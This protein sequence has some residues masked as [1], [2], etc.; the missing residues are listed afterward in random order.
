M[1][2][3]TKFYGFVLALLGVV[4]LT[5]CDNDDD[6]LRLSEVPSVVLAALDAKYPDVKHAEW[7]VKQG[8]YVAD[9]WQ[10]GMETHVWINKNA[11]WKMTELDLGKNLSLL[12]QAVQDA[13]QSGQYASWRVDDIDKYERPDRTFYVIEVE[14]NGQ[15]DHDLFF[16]GSGNILKDEV[17]KNDKDVTPDTSLD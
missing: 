4:V 9:F 7:E 13:F 8:Y 15:P 6:D 10:E 2:M 1:M 5:G 14:T 3:K 16:D 17:D 11:D 12:P